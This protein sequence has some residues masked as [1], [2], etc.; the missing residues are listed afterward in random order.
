MKRNLLHIFFAFISATSLAQPYNIGH[1]TITFNDPSR[2][3]G[4]GSGGGPGRQIQTEIYYPAA[5]TGTNVSLTGGSHPVIV[6]GHGFVMAWDAYQNIW[7]ELVPRGYILVFPRTE[8]GFSPSHN[9]FGLDLALCVTK[10]QEQNTLPASIFYNGVTTNSAIM[11]H[12]MGGGATFLAAAN[13]STIQTIIGLAPAETN[14]SAIAA[15]GQVTVP[16]LV[17]SGSSDGVTPPATHHLPIYNALANVCKHFV[18]VTG[19]AHCYFAN[20]NFNCDFGEGTSSSGITVTRAEQHQITFDYINKWLDFKLKNNCSAWNEFMTLLSSDIRTTY[21]SDCPINTPVIAANGST[22]LCFGDSLQLSATSILDWSNNST[23][24]SI[25]VSSAGTYS[26]ID[27]TTCA[28][29]NTITVTVAAPLDTSLSASGT[30]ITSNATAVQYQWI[31]CANGN[32]PIVGANMQQFTAVTPGSFAVIV[33]NGACADTSSCRMIEP[34]GVL[35]HDEVSFRVYPNPSSTTFNLAAT[36][37]EEVQLE[38]TNQLGQ[39]LW[40]REVL[41][42][43]GE[44]FEI[45]TPN[46]LHFIRITT[47]N[48][49]H[50][51]KVLKRP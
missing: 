41:F 45:D 34:L 11:G 31:D 9:E 30:T 14:P 3:G 44:P 8:G 13:N 29:S 6:F 49:Q 50:Y 20:P 39:T 5:T 17:M 43:A 10:L 28:T 26:A 47:G 25:T 4:F 37:S 1:T 23:G 19:G 7:E 32:T 16:A 42:I 22:N 2:T 15:S 33:S 38:L 35:H 12:S 27:P 46:G 24:N 48:T 40:R 51:F 18:S 21:L 36:Q